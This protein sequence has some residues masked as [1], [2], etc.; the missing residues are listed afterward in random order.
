MINEMLWGLLYESTASTPLDE[1]QL[2]ELLAEAQRRNG[3]L[4]VTG[5]LMYTPDPDGTGRFMQ[6]I[7][8]PRSSIERLFYGLDGHGG[9]G[10]DARHTDVRIIHEG[11]FGGGPPGERLY[12][13]W[14]MEWVKEIAVPATV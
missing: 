7:E 4:S 6:Y 14:M 1:D 2:Q 11:A 5:W 12:P 8:G 3:E 9:I 10:K 13:R